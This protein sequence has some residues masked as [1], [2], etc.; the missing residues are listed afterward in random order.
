MNRLR[1]EIF[2]AALGPIETKRPGMVSRRF[3]FQGHFIGFS[4]HFPGYPV[5]PAFV[6]VLM[7]LMVIEEWKDRTL[8][9]FTI[10]KAKFHIELKPDQEIIVE[11]REYDAKGR[12][13]VE[14]KLS[15]AEA[16]AAVFHVNLAG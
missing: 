4:G 16:L 14:V 15:V 6:Q 10:E 13:A 2:E 8:Q 3:S 5:L 9:L 7:G 1:K 12:P 11:C